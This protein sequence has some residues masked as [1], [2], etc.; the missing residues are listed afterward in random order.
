MYLSE[1]ILKK[2]LEKCDPK[3]YIKVGL[4]SKNLYKYVNTCLE[5]EY[6]KSEKLYKYIEV[7]YEQVYISDKYKGCVYCLK[8]EKKKKKKKE[9]EY[10]GI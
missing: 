10:D 2:I 3:T 9:K 6:K 5:R 1:D 7:T 8:K 4:S